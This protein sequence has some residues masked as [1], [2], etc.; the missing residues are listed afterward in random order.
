MAI[1][2]TSFNKDCIVK[3]NAYVWIKLQAL[4]G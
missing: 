2:I 1:E 4:D 3:C